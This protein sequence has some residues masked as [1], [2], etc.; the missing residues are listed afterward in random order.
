[1][2]MTYYKLEDERKLVGYRAYFKTLDEL[3]LYSGNLVESG[4][5]EPIT[6]DR[7][8][9]PLIT[10]NGQMPGPT[11]TASEIRCFM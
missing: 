9:R 11:I 10:V 5:S 2:S 1:M 7:E 6:T 8:F 3:A 4:T